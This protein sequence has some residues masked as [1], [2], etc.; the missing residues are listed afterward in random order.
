MKISK[1]MLLVAE[2]SSSLRLRFR[3]KFQL[4]GKDFDRVF[5]TVSYCFKGKFFTKNIWKKVLF[6]NSQAITYEY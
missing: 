5:Q 6:L 4:I 1:R 3:Q 2:V